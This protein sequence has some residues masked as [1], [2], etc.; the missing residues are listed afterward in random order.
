ME[1][2]R[3]AITARLKE[4]TRIN[5]TVALWLGAALFAF[6]PELLRL[7]LSSE[8]TPAIVQGFRVAV[9]IYAAYSLNAVGYFLLLGTGG[10]RAT[11]LIVLSGALLSIVLIWIGAGRYELLGA[12]L[13]NA[14]F[15]LTALLTIFAM[16]RVRIPL[17]A[18]LNWMSMQIVWFFA[19][20]AA[21][22]VFS[23]QLLMRIGV[24]V[25]ATAVMTA[26]WIK[27]EGSIAPAG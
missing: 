26:W 9:V 22:E 10:E 19:T 17:L 2:E 15:F 5:A 4:A 16:R 20:L 14:G 25:V 3:S 12:V 24:V 27:I 13:G 11:S 1:S 8:A 23:E 21:L 7:I 6:A 18:C